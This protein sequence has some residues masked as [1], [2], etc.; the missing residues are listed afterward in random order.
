VNGDE[1]WRLEGDRFADSFNPRRA[2]ASDRG[3]IGY[4]KVLADG[5][6]DDPWKEQWA[7]EQVVSDLATILGIPAIEA[8]AGEVEGEVG[9]ITVFMEGHKLSELE[10]AGYRVATLLDVALNRDQLGL[11]VAFDV[12]ILNIDRSAGNLFITTEE[13]RPRL[14]LL[15]HGHTLLLPRSE[16]GADPPPSDWDAWV[17]SGVLETPEMAQRLSSYLRQFVEKEEIVSGAE[18]IAELSD[19]DLE[20]AV[21]RVP[22]EFIFCR[23]SAILGLLQNRR[24]RLANVIQEAL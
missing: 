21:D 6:A 17:T 5:H 23:R 2:I 24:D 1:V 22:E 4:L 11:I 13:G 8:H 16:K 10:Q 3:R 14:R 15:D 18:R 9:A 12:L 20:K 19:Q 7:N